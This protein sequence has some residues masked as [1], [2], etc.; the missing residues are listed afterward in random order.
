M[1]NFYLDIAVLVPLKNTFLYKPLIKTTKEQYK[2][3]SRVLVP[4]RSRNNMVGIV[5]K[6][7]DDE[8][9]FKSYNVND[10]KIKSITG[11]IDD[12][13]IFDDKILNLAKWISK[14]YFAPIGE[15]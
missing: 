9:I 11:N 12:N 6:I 1:Q 4:F 15:V 10:A 2:V 3:G 5:V 7:I 13:A 14:Y 8:K